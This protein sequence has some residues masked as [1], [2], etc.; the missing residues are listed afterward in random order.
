MCLLG[1]AFASLT[2]TQATMVRCYNYGVV[3]QPQGMTY[4]NA[5]F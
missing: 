5:G 3:F 1:L 4:P 2:L